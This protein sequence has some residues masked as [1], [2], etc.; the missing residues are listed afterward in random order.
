MDDDAGLEM[1]L[2]LDGHS[3]EAAS[4]YVV[5]F[6]VRRTE[7]T[8]E[9]PHGISYSLVFRPLDGEPFVRFDNAHAVV[10]PGGRFVKASRSFDHWH[11]TANDPGRPYAFMTATQ[12][13]ADFW[14]E[15]K[16]VMDEMELP[17]DL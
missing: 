17:N 7:K 2:S 1:L 16:R 9:R 15:V 13:L 4:G 3:Y 6:V 12:L 8:A 14:S 10:R 5:E 11:R